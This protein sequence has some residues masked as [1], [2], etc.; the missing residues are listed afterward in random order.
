MHVDM[1]LTASL[2]LVKSN[3]RHLLLMWSLWETR[4]SVGYLQVEITLG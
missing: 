1:E 3:L 4:I 2:V